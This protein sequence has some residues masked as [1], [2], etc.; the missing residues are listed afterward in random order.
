M[1]YGLVGS[2]METSYKSEDG[3]DAHY[4]GILRGRQVRGRATASAC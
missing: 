1:F 4:Y 3:V 2:T